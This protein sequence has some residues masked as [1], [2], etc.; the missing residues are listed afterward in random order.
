VSAGIVLLLVLTPLAFGTVE[1]W[2]VSIMEAAA[3]GLFAL[4]A[5]TAGFT[6]P[7]GRPAR[8]IL[9]L[10]LLLVALVLL[11]LLPLPDFLL[12]LISPASLELH[13]S[14]GAARPGGF[15]TVSIA[16]DATF[17]ELVKLLSYAAVFCVVAARFRTTEQIRPLVRT[18]LFMGVLL[19]VLAVAQKLSW[20]GKILWFYPASKDVRSNFGIWGPYVNRNHF[21]GYLAMVIP[22]GLGLL[23]DAAPVAKEVP[24]LCWSRR[25][26]RTLTHRDLPHSAVLFLLV[27]LMAICLLATLSRSGI[28][29][30]AAASLFFFWITWRRRTLRR[31]AAQFALLAA[32]VG[33]AVLLPSLGLLVRR[34]AAVGQGTGLARLDV[35]RDSVGILKDFP[36]LGA[37]LGTYGQIFRRYQEHYTRSLFDH[38]H[39]DYLEMAADTGALGFLLAAGMA[40]IF[41]VVLMRGWKH[42]HGMFGKSFGA[43]GIASC[44]GVAVMSA[45]DFNLRIPANALLFTVVAALTYAAIFNHRRDSKGEPGEEIALRRIPFPRRRPLAVIGTI[46]VACLVISFPARAFLADRHYRRGARLLDAGTPDK[47]V[48]KPLSRDTIPAYIAAAGS[49]ARA[50]ALAPSRPAYR[51][52]LADVYARMGVWATTMEGL[53]APL[54]AGV[55][56]GR[57]ALAKAAK[58]MSVAVRLEPTNPEHHLALGRLHAASGDAARAGVEFGKAAEALPGNAPLRHTVAAAYLGI[59]DTAAALGHAVALA[60]L[61]AGY[62]AR[63]L[64]IAASASADDATLQ[65]MIP[66]NEAAKAVLEGFMKSKGSGR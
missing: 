15:N 22:L 51:R 25:L 62:L 21:A 10:F 6:F 64:A 46:V 65:A 9:S 61:D 42:K 5:G 45:V 44:I 7:Q 4:H 37:G 55:I 35:W 59:G 23:L 57:E 50:T 34:F 2:S 43:G 14:L 66:P 31:R 19:T 30:V 33:A 40:V 52:A 49:L 8:A 12:R 54:P 13:R 58:E 16:P 18:I 20:N 29:A 24:G 17:Q 36:L 60:R 39:N 28:T 3:F 48:L 56:S 63:A 27:L 11:Q 41:I 1:P 38:A 47:P 53:G 32:V 26:W